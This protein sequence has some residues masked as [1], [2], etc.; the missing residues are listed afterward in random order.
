MS[1]IGAS[2]VV[3]CISVNAR[4]RWRGR[5][6]RRTWW[7]RVPTACRG[8]FFNIG[9]QCVLGHNV[10]LSG[11]VAVECCSR[12]VFYLCQFEYVCDVQPSYIPLVRGDLIRP[13][14]CV[15]HVSCLS[16]AAKKTLARSCS[17]TSRVRQFCA[18]TMVVQTVGVSTGQ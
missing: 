8:A 10:Y 9:G 17:T 12:P 5:D 7:R 3:S 16:T 14:G 11:T 6:W 2:S 13:T 18:A 15:C 4:Q 1:L